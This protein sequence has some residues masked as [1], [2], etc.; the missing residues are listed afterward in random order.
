MRRFMSLSPLHTITA[1][2][3]KSNSAD[4]RHAKV[5]KF[6]QLFWHICC[7]QQSMCIYEFSAWQH[8]AICSLESNVVY[9]YL[10]A[11]IICGLCVLVG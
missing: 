11:D 4:V 3:N 10:Q 1:Y 2:M 5:N 7:H 8:G 9:L 6:L